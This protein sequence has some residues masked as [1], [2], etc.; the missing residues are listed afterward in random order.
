VN[1]F[2]NWNCQL[3]NSTIILN[4][5]KAFLKKHQHLLC[6]V[7]IW[8]KVVEHLNLIEQRTSSE[9]EKYFATASL[10]H[11]ASLQPIIKSFLTIGILMSAVLV[12]IWTFLFYVTLTNGAP[13]FVYVL[14]PV[15]IAIGLGLLGSLIYALAKTP[16]WIKQVKEDT[17]LRPKK[18]KVAALSLAKP[19]LHE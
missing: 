8:K 1:C 11:K 19:N 10:S 2:L 18:I 7:A 12:S 14:L 16:L 3:A 9:D 4:S 15:L 5:S 13:A 17:S 6:V